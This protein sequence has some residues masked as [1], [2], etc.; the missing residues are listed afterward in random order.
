VNDFLAQSRVRQAALFVVM[1]P[2]ALAHE[3]RVLLQQ[4]FPH[5]IAKAAHHV[6]LVDGKQSRFA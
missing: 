3:R 5:Y 6:Y 4:H 2:L 1:A